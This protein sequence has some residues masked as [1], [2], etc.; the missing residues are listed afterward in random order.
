[1]SS[2]GLYYGVLLFYRN[3]GVIKLTGRKPPLSLGPPQT[4][5][6]VKPPLSLGPPQTLIPPVKPPL[7]VKLTSLK[8]VSPSPLIVVCV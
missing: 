2:N 4:L 3:V 7:P 5:L 8:P 6:P 1:M